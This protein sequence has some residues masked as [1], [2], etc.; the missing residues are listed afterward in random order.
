MESG[1]RLMWNQ[2][3]PRLTPLHNLLGNAVEACFW[4]IY[5]WVFSIE[6]PPNTLIDLLDLLFTEHPRV[7]EIHT[8]KLAKN[9]ASV[10]EID[11][12]VSVRLIS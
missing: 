6:N 4:P 8:K 10:V 5:I 9:P 3:W 11:I 7:I 1:I 12:P 2:I